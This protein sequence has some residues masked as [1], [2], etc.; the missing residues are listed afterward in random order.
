[1]DNNIGIA[2]F[3][4]ADSLV[5]EVLH[6][7]L[8]VPQL[9]LQLDLLVA[10]P[11]Q[12]SAQV[13]DVGLEHGVHVAACGGLFLQQLPLGF[14]HL[15]LLLQVADLEVDLPRLASLLLWVLL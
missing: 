6:Q 12:L 11:I 4:A 13:G 5:L 1:M 14:Q 2:L 10:E 9:A 7:G 15:V 8:H 3:R